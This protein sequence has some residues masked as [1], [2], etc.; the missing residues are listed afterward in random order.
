MFGTVATTRRS[1]W[2][3]GKAA[4]GQFE[5]V[6]R[7]TLAERRPGIRERIGE[8]AQRRPAHGDRSIAPRIDATL[9]IAKPGAAD[10]DAADE[11]DRV[12]DH[13]Q[14]AV[15]AR[16]P[17]E[18]TGEMQRIVTCALRRRRRPAAARR[19]CST[20]QAAH[21]VA[22][23]AHTHAGTGTLDQRIAELAAG[24]VVAENVVLEQHQRLR[25]ANRGKP[26]IEVDARIDQEI[27]RVA[28]K[29][30]RTRST[31][32][33]LLGED[34]HGH[35]VGNNAASCDGGHARSLRDQREHAPVL[36]DLR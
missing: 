14:L 30:R 18:R 15:I 32:E 35:A 10:A 34:A 33:R 4:V 28:G 26:R 2:P 13:E 27:D 17:A 22:D 3:A 21:P 6:V 8:I 11:R 23:H 12:V 24:G 36:R 7:Q 19:Q 1:T 5:D 20:G 31:T 29:Q 16:K 9:G 25:C